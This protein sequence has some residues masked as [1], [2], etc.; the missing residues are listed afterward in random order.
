[1]F[2]KTTNK[3]RAKKMNVL[4]APVNNT[5]IRSELLEEEV[6]KSFE[7][8]EF[9]YHYLDES[10]TMPTGVERAAPWHFCSLT[11]EINEIEKNRCYKI[12]YCLMYV[13]E[14]IENLYEKFPKIDFYVLLFPKNPLRS[15]AI[16]SHSR[17]F[18]CVKN[19]IGR[20]I[21]A[22]VSIVKYL[23]KN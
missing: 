15:G 7:N 5:E 10:I 23:D 19:D 16:S 12:N 20:I 22:L 6:S 14:E 8:R 18:V 4:F 11:E 17:K 9:D 2:P 13:L 1:M 21:D 3:P